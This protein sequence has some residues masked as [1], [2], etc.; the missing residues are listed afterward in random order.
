MSLELTI[1]I[2]KRDLR[3]VVGGSVKTPAHHSVAGERKSVVTRKGKE[4]KTENAVIYVHGSLACQIPCLVLIA[5]QTR[6]QN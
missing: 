2:Q 5:S 1:P 4:H 6:Q 3:D